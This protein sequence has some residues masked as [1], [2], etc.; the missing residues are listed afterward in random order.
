[1]LRVLRD[2]AQALPLPAALGAGA[3]LGPVAILAVDRVGPRARLAAALLHLVDV[4]GAAL[5]AVLRLADEAAAPVL[6]AATSARHAAVAPQAPRVQLAVDG[7]LGLLAALRVVLALARVA[8]RRLLQRPLAPRAL[9]R[10]EPLD[11][12]R[13]T[14]HAAARARAV[15]PM[16]PLGELAVDALAAALRVA[17]RD[18]AVHA[19]GRLAALAGHLLDLARAEGL[20]TAAGGGAWG[21]GR[22]VRPGA[23]LAQLAVARLRVAGLDLLHVLGRA[24]VAATHR[25]LGHIAD[26]HLVPA[27]AVLR[28][29]APLLPVAPLAVADIARLDVLALP[30]LAEARVAALAGQAPEREHVAHALLEAR[31]AGRRAGG[32]IRPL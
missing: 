14:L 29:V 7:L 24:G 13:A 12:P 8:R 28:A 23:V 18:F 9:A 5:A 30:R 16:S 22:P 26:P 2:L 25:S 15:S 20:A 19:L 27:A 21:P 17:E 11:L 10:A 6:R 3:P 4:A 31:A 1:M 32:P